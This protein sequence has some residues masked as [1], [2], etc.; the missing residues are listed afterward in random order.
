MAKVLLHLNTSV[1]LRSNNS[2][3]SP[4]V[5]P[6]VRQGVRCPDHP[7]SE[8]VG[9][10]CR[11]GRLRRACSIR[12]RS[13]RRSTASSNNSSRTY[14]SGAAI[15]VKNNIIESIVQIILIKT[16]FLNLNKFLLFLFQFNLFWNYFNLI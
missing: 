11:H 9:R 16:N 3:A 13:A 4:S 14:S 15:I 10:R 8:L 7:R 2:S 1:P 6:V 5:A 12:C